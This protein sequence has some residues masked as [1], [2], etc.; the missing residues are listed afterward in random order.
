MTRNSRTARSNF[1]PRRLACVL[2]ILV[3]CG[4]DNRPARDLAPV[5]G[6]VLFDGKPLQEGAIIT[7]PEHGRGAHGT[8]DANGRF[9]LSTRG[10]G[11]GAMVGPH[12]VAVVV[13]SGDSSAAVNPEAEITLAVPSRYAQAASSGLNIDVKP[14]QINDVTFELSSGQPR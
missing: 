7:T 8:I 2:A 4:C 13:T 3:C 6:I 12:Q 5:Q 1:A 14:N 11:E 10:L 9:S